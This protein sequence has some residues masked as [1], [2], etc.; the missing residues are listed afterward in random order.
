MTTASPYDTVIR[1]S[2]VDGISGVL[3]VIAA[4]VMGLDRNFKELNTS[5]KLALT[6]GAMVAAGVEIGKVLHHLEEAGEKIVHVK[7]L[8]E[9]ALPVQSRMADMAKITG[10]AWKEAGDNMRTTATDNISALHDLYNVVQDVN[11]ASKLLH[12]YNVLKNVVDST[13]GKL[14]D[15]GIVSAIQ[16]V[17]IAGRTTPESLQAATETLAGSVIA[18]GKRFDPSQF[19]TNILTSGDARF[20]WNDE[21]LT[22]GLPAIIA[23]GGG[24][25]TGS[26]MYQMQ[27]NLWGGGGGALASRIQATAQEKWGLHSAEDELW[28]GKKFKGFKVGSVFEADKL[29]ANPIDWANDYREKLRSMGV[30]TNDMARMAVIVG[31]I[32]RGNKLL[33][34]GLDE[35]L[36]PKTNAQLNREMRNINNVGP[37][38]TGILN[39]ND[40]KAIHQAIQAQWENV[41]EAIGENF[42]KPFLDSI[43]KPLTEVFKN[44]SQWAAV[45]P[46]KVMEV[47]KAAAAIGLAMASIG[48]VLIGAGIVAAVSAMGPVALGIAAV[49]SAIAAAAS[50]YAI[51]GSKATDFM[52]GLAGGIQAGVAGL[53]S[54]VGTAVKLINDGMNALGS[55]ISS[56]ISNMFSSIRGMLP[57]WMPGSLPASPAAPG[58]TTPQLEKH[59]SLVP[60]ARST[61]VNLALTATLD[62]RKLTQVVTSQMVASATYPTSAAGADSRGTWM[63]PSWSPTEMG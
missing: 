29:R 25:R 31:D 56:A 42:V 9:A 51:Y 3:G 44:V 32:G 62:G 26:M 16:G 8:F 11:E 37:D 14:G 48:S 63:G 19:K 54:A 21:F 22:K 13:G 39:A 10:A 24:N 23:L 17:D 7:T 28:D 6:G 45:N 35:L 41:K 4:K 50:G 1:L 20:G 5:M 30:D 38:A 58:A 61:T 57:S 2:C 49:G 40:P 36:L 55:A 52:L 18:L 60:P 59:S 46:E 34:A 53:G 15:K 27:N 47:G 33:K 43:I 12:P